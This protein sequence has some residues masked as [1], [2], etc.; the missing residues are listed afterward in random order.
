MFERSHAAGGHLNIAQIMRGGSPDNP[1]QRVAH[2][3]LALCLSARLRA[4]FQGDGGL[5]G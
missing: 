4:P 1:R 3:F 5:I 2:N